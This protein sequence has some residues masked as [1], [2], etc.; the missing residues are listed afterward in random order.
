M[1]GGPYLVG[2]DGGTQSSKVVVFDAAGNIAAEGRRVLRPLVRPRHGI[3]FHPDD[4]L[5]DSIAGACRDALAAFT[6]NREEIAGV[7]L[8]TIR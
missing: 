7:G 5:W 4:D 1:A 6:G 3:A 8:C 2:I